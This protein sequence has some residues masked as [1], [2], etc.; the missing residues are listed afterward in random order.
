MDIA[1]QGNRFE[2]FATEIAAQDD[3]RIQMVCIRP[4]GAFAAFDERLS[5]VALRQVRSVRVSIF[6]TWDFAA[7][8]DLG[9]VSPTLPTVILV[10]DGEVVAK[11]IGDVPQREL[12]EMLVRAAPAE[13]RR[14]A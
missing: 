3:G 5:T 10:R 7:H 8:H 12:E 13:A 6:R 9:F 2:Q 1:R 14:A 11:A 4:P